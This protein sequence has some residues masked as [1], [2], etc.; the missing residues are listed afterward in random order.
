MGVDK[1]PI[2]SG[3]REGSGRVRNQIWTRTANWTEHLDSI[4]LSIM[5]E[6]HTLGNYVNGSF[7][8]VAWVRII[9]S[10]NSKSNQN[11][12]KNQIKNRLKV[13]KRLYLTYY[14][15]AHKSGWGWDCVNNIPTAGDPSDWDAV[16][17]ENPAYAK[18][19]DKP[20][21]AY[22]DIE[23]LSGSTTA[24]GRFAMSSQMPVATIDSSSS[25]SPGEEDTIMG[26]REISLNYLSPRFEPG[27]SSSPIPENV[28]GNN[29]SRSSSPPLVPPNVGGSASGSGYSSAGKRPRSPQSSIPP[30]KQSASAAGRKKKSDIAGE[31][32]VEL[33]EIGKQKLDFVKHMYQQDTSNQSSIP[34]IEVCM[35]RVYNLPGITDEQAL[36]AGEA[37]MNDKH[38]R[39]FMTMKDRLAIRWIER[40]VSLQDVLYK[41]NFSV[42]S[43]TTLAN[44]MSILDDDDDYWDQ[45]YVI[46]FG[47]DF[48]T[49]SNSLLYKRP[50][51]TRPFT[52]HQMVCDI[53]NG[54][55]DRGYDQFRMTTTSFVAL[56]DV[57]LARGLIRGTRY[58]TADEQLAIFLFCVGHGVANRVLAET[59]QHS[60]ET[61]SRHFNNVLRGIVMLK[62]DYLSLPPN[63]AMV[64]PRIRDN[65]NFHPF[66]VG[67]DQLQIC[68]YFDGHATVEDLQ[69]QMVNIIWLIR[70]TQTP[71]NFLH[72]TE[73]SDII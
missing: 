15:L 50:C 20:F 29:T 22:K 8:Q 44:I 33:V 24:T 12:S 7:T 34:S 57:L 17:A 25:S 11:L 67:K 43:S 18:C 31:A 59:F 73:V 68:V 58:M 16:I 35:E 60:G 54:H 38:R 69:F 2:P 49:F 10:F 64:H 42:F 47:Q 48:L 4:L 13:L 52:G 14:T 41:R 32:I 66:K 1:N 28:P 45:V 36:A 26:V 65:L 3:D 61:I 53:L 6:E 70:G 5:M 55:P 30:K 37:L 71:T 9:S 39:L 23:F 19:R 62:D 56:R 72:P 21:A 46:L 40:Q 51:R 27:S 63:N